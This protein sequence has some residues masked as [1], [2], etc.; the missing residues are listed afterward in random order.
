MGSLLTKIGRLFQY[1]RK[2]GWFAVLRKIYIRIDGPQWA[3]YWEKWFLY[4][5]LAPHW[6]RWI[7]HHWQ[8][9]SFYPQ[10]QDWQEESNTW[11]NCPQID[12]F[13]LG[14]EFDF[15]LQSITSVQSQIYPHWQLHVL[16]KT[17]A[18]EWPNSYAWPQDDRIRY[19]LINQD[20][21]FMTV[22]NRILQE[23]EGEWMVLQF[24]GDQL[25]AYA[26]HEIVKVLQHNEVDM[27]YTDD[28][29]LN[30]RDQR[31]NPSFKP[32]WSPWN[33]LTHNYIRNLCVIR[34]EIVRSLKGI[35]EQESGA[36]YDL[37]IRMSENLP[38][39]R[40]WHI[41]QV[42]YHHW[43][44]RS[45]HALSSKW[46]GLGEATG[47][48]Q[49]VQ[50]ALKRRA[51]EAKLTFNPTLQIMRIYP[52]LKAT[53]LVSIIIPFRDQFPLLNQAITSILQ[54]STY[55][56][57]EIVL[58]DNQSQE[59]T[60]QQVSEVI[61]NHAQIRLLT[62]PHPF[63]Y[64]AINNFAASQTKGEFLVLLN[65]DIEVLTPEWLEWMLAYA[66]F[67]QHGAIGA[68]L[69]YPN[70]LLQHAG[71]ITGIFGVAGHAHRFAQKGSAGYGLCLESIREVSAVTAACLMV[72][73]SLYHQMGG[74]DVEHLA[75]AFNDVD[76]CLRLHL[77][78]YSNLFLPMVEMTHHESS[79]RGK[80]ITLEQQNRIQQEI[81]TMQQ[82][83]GS[84]LTDDPFYNPNLT[85]EAEDF[86][87]RFP[88]FHLRS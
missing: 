24:A 76:F 37:L 47:S 32:N 85:L 73:K 82:R 52:E 60:K 26:F 69:Y 39:E 12:V 35:D 71:I 9:I 7:Y 29:H 86:F 61:Q 50:H 31:F 68:K 30:K 51:I 78:G 88:P 56:H 19:R 6:Q 41:P 46:Y 13:L 38:S 20:S 23:S 22:F 48:V 87:L 43:M 10:I 83:W 49:R 54:K 2:A 62:Y 59:S 57:F 11:R 44:E 64:S 42:L 72:R 16:I 3:P 33:F 55:R 53:P 28:D 84:R 4:Q 67:P 14:D 58:V 25:A 77:N 18:T 34:Y 65:N 17:L 80:E 79:T 75:V 70:E 40:I 1:W 5:K 63:N 36:F 21:S 66:Q 8:N 81:Q 45:S 27:I 15:L 74:M